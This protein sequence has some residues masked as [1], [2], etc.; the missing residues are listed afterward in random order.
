MARKLTYKRLSRKNSRFYTFYM[1]FLWVS[2]AVIALGWFWLHRELR[3]YEAG[4]P[5][6]RAEEI[7]R[8]VTTGD[9]T[10]LMEVLEADSP[11]QAEAFR[12][13]LKSANPGSTY[14]ATQTT[15]T[16]DTYSYNLTCNGVAVTGFTLERHMSSDSGKWYVSGVQL[17]SET[18]A[19][20]VDHNAAVQLE[21]VIS[22]VVTCDYSQLY[23]MMVPTGFSEDNKDVFATFMTS[24]TPP[25]TAFTYSMKEAGT[26]R[27][28][29]IYANDQTFAMMTMVRNE[30]G[31]WQITEFSVA[32][33]IRTS[34]VVY[35]ADRRANEVLD[36]FKTGNTDVI[37]ACCV[38]NGYPG[39]AAEDFGAFLKPLLEGREFQ[40]SVYAASDEDERSYRVD[41]GDVKYADFVIR[42]SLDGE[43]RVC[44][45]VSDF[46]LPVWAP[47]SVQV[48][49]PAAFTVFAGENVL[50]EGDIVS[51]GSVPEGTPD[52]LLQAYP[53]RFE[54]VTYRAEG[55]FREPS[56]LAVDWNGRVA[57][58]EKTG[59]RTYACVSVADDEDLKLEVEGRVRAFCENFSYFTMNDVSYY[60]MLEYVSAGSDV[61]KYML[62]YDSMWV[63]KHNPNSNKFYDFESSNYVKY[64]D[65]M[66]SC[67]VKFKL[68]VVYTYGGKTEY[69][70]SYRLYYEKVNGSWMVFAFMNTVQ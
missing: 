9:Y 4:Q 43:G 14:S 62:G 48:T 13:S 1:I 3:S 59:E 47:V 24:V 67:D 52:K 33:S 21:T 2:V 49:A 16:A 30:T 5:D 39:G 27:Y 36:L 54:T 15:S 34:Y 60:G 58:V 32:D 70:P 17:D 37:Y 66:F 28:Y 10:E 64:G 55:A 53:D 42:R 50:G 19:K 38:A 25:L 29:T 46:R 68:S 40:C 31:A 44:W 11:E 12:Y 6:S 51:R 7:A 8:S 65:N 41:S 23:S 56:L 20:Y 26:S 22:R 57:A 45:A 61:A 35:L 69:T 63:K 18:L